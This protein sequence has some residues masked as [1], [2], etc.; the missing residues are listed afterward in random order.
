MMVSFRGTFGADCTN[1]LG[2]CLA[3]LE[4][5]GMKAVILHMA[6]VEDIT[7]DGFR[8]LLLFTR[9]LKESSLEVQFADFPAPV[10]HLVVNEGLLSFGEANATLAEAVRGYAGWVRGEGA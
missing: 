6:S 5:Q 8:P 4:G 10:R 2:E 9:A 7:R 1:V 3:A